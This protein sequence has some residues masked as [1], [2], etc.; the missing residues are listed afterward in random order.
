V[1]GNLALCST[2]GGGAYRVDPPGRYHVKVKVRVT[3]IY[4]AP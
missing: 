2:D 1:T 4:V 3:L